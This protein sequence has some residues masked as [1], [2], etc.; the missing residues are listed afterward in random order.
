MLIDYAS[1]FRFPIQLLP[2]F[3]HRKVDLR[4]DDELV[5]R[6]AQLLDSIP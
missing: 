5:A 3:G 2:I 6:E 4:Q 1:V